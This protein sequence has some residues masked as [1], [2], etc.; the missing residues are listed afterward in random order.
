MPEEAGNGVFFVGPKM[1]HVS[2]ESTKVLNCEVLGTGCSSP[3]RDDKRR[4]EGEQGL[5]GNGDGVRLDGPP[6]LGQ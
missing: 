3:S 4:R 5:G 1:G 2:I 6:G